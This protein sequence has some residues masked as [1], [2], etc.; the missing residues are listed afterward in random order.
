MKKLLV[1]NVRVWTMDENNTRYEGWVLTDEGRITELG[2]G[3]PPESWEIKTIDGLGGVLTPGLIDVHSHV[4]LYEDGLGFEGA[5]GN[6]DTDPATPQLRAIDGAN[7]MDR[8]FKE[9]LEA[10]I[11]C[12]AISPGS[13]NP[14]GGQIALVKTAGNRIDDMLLKSPLA[15]KF[16]LGENPKSVYHSKDD[17]PVTRMATAAII[18]E[19]LYKAKEYQKRKQHALVDPDSEG[20]DYDF[21]LEALLPLIE[22]KIQAH[23]HA[24]RADDIFTALRISK[25]FC[26][27]PVIIHGTD[28][29]LV[30]DCLKKE[31]VPV[32]YGPF[33]TDRSKPELKNLTEKA[34]GILR[35]AGV[36]TAITV[37]HPETPL[38]LLRTALSIAVGAGMSELDAMRAVTTVPA[39]ISG[40]Q[41]RIGSIQKN[42]D[43]DL[44]LW[45]G[46]PLHY[47]TRIKTVIVNGEPQKLES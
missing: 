11:T 40:M 2:A 38:R 30:A 32:V 17:T 3:E 43:A 22:G 15:I 41:D 8:S 13:A 1:K 10:G 14:I 44:V 19:Q 4:G 12:V 46:D 20:P 29:H 42:L 37:D 21:K 24:H 31:N 35:K 6:E 7:P 33:M 18:R 5:D 28:A 45:S 27:K 23:F 34:P 16:A 25:E 9:A 36:T 39:E 26:L 47:Q